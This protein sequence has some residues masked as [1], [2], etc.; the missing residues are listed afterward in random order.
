MKEID[1]AGEAKIINLYSK[2]R[3][4][5]CDVWNTVQRRGQELIECHG[6]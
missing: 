1:D 4:G 5:I 2:A 6:L 3:L